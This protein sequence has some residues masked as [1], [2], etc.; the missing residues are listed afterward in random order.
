MLR[1]QGQGHLARHGLLAVALLAALGLVGTAWSSRRAAEDLRGT[2]NDGQAERVMRAMREQMPA[3]RGKASDSA[4]EAFFESQ[5][6]NG[7]RGIGYA[8]PGRD[9]QVLVGEM[10]AE[11]PS[12]EDF[13]PGPH[14]RQVGSLLRLFTPSAGELMGPPPRHR[15]GDSGPPGDSPPPRE[16][17]SGAPGDSPPP[18]DGDNGPP[19]D[20]SSTGRRQRA[21]GRLA[22]SGPL[23]GGS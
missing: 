23:G 7:I 21:S 17:D 13:R 18:R 19:G 4:M 6:A 1:V 9:L 2:L 11:K 10:S 22:S 20:S 12:E 3:G 8:A 14:A 15:R 5:K 16:G